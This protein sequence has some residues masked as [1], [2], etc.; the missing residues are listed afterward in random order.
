MSAKIHVFRIKPDKELLTE[1]DRY[2]SEHTISSGI[3]I[4]I[5]GSLKCA[6]LN[7]I[8]KLPGK[9]N[10]VDYN[11]PLEIVCA[12]GSIALKDTTRITHIHAQLSNQNGCYGGHL[13]SAIVFS[14]AEVSIAELDYQLKRRYDSYTGIHELIE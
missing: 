4:G 8:V 7:Y 5:I 6:T 1:I 10:G 2:C 12:Q 14:T 13:V 11:G 9:Y 3:V